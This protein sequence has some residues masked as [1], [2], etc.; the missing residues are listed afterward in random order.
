MKQWRSGKAHKKSREWI[1]EKKEGRRREGKETSEDFK[2]SGRLRPNR[3][4]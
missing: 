1:L 3:V 4:W 2:Y